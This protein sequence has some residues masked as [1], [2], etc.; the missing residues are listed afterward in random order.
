[1]YIRLIIDNSAQSD[2]GSCAF[3]HFH[4]FKS[5]LSLNIHRDLVNSLSTRDENS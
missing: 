4:S 3:L 1:M 2:H 5:N